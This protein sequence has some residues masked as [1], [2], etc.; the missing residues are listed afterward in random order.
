MG[1]NSAIG[2]ITGSSDIARLEAELDKDRAT[3]NR[4]IAALENE[5]KRLKAQI[6]RLEARK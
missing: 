5:V 6:N 2:K 1:I 4:R 3:T